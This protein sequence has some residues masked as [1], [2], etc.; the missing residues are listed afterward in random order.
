MKFEEKIKEIRDGLETI[1]NAS[2]TKKKANRQRFFWALSM[3]FIILI[4]LI[5]VAMP[6]LAYELLYQ[7]KIYVGV[8]IDGINVG[9]LAKEEA[10]VN[11]REAIQGY[12]ASM[13]KH[14][15]PIHSI[16]EVEEVEVTV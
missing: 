4:V 2:K 3:F 7:N 14:G 11:I 15:E 13:R 16:T 1:F 5:L 12:I 6:I 9:G 10:I 8:S